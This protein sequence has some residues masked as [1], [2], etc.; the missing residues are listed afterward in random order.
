M[1]TSTLPCELVFPRRFGAV[2]IGM[3]TLVYATHGRIEVTEGRNTPKKFENGVKFLSG[4]APN[5]SCRQFEE[6]RTAGVSGTGTDSR[7]EKNRGSHGYKNFVFLN[8]ENE[9]VRYFFF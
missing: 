1:L 5:V 3:N 8:H 2:L 4:N 7:T 9:Q 6:A